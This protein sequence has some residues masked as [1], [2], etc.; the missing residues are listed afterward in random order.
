MKYTEKD[1]KKTLDF[2]KRER[3]MTRSA[4]TMNFRHLNAGVIDQDTW[5]RLYDAELAELTILNDNIS[6]VEAVYEY[7][8]AQRLGEPF[9]ETDE[10]SVNVY[11]AAEKVVEDFVEN[12]G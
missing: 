11:E 4:S 12:E 1:Y 10:P 8:L 9:E 3:D 2:L 5:K 6:A 7:I